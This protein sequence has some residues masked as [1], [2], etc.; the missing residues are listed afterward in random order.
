MAENQPAKKVV[1]NRN[2]PFD[3]RAHY[4]LFLIR[5]LHQAKEE[6]LLEAI[7][8]SDRDNALYLIRQGAD[9]NW[10]DEYGLS[11]HNKMIL[12]FFFLLSL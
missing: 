1:G 11:V 6:L 9:V 3:C 7:R 5:D 10:S 4:N 12:I 8:T 2:H